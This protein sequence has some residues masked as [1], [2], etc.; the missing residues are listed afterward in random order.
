MEDSRKS[1]CEEMH[2]LMQALGAKEAGY[3]WSRV[4]AICAAMAWA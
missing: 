4:G 2:A 1:L 3:K